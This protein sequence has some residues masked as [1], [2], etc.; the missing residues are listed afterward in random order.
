MTKTRESPYLWATWLPKLIAGEDH[1]FWKAWFKA[2]FTEYEKLQDDSFDLGRWTADHAF[3]VYERA[4][5]LRD[6]GYEVAVEGQNKFYLE[7]RAGATLS[8]QPDIVAKRDAD[9]LIVDCKTGRPR[10]SDKV[11]V[12]IYML[13]WPHVRPEADGME[14][15]GEIEYSTKSIDIPIADAD[16]GFRQ[17]V[18]YLITDIAGARE[19]ARVPCF[20]ECEYCDISAAD[21]PARVTEQLQPIVVDLF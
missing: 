13:V 1:C 11:Q 6:E 21:C 14:M 17:A 5:R 3:M 15:R 9:L 7:T 4:K 2:H 18:R 16:E 19:L 10:Y 12:L 8:G 20:D